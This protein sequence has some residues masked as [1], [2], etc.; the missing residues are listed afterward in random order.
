MG[1]K[2]RNMRQKLRDGKEKRRIAGMYLA[3][4]THVDGYNVVGQPQKT[5]W[6]YSSEDEIW[7][8]D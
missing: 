3:G 7:E 8:D 1:S 4:Q 6:R 2:I 5:K